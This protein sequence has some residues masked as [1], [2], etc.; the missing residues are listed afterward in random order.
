MPT[1]HIETHKCAKDGICIA[2]CPFLLLEEAE[3]GRARF[4][5][6]AETFCIECGHCL[7]VCP[8][9]A[10]R[11]NGVGQEQL[12]HVDRSLLPGPEQTAAWLRSRRSVRSYKD[13]PVPAGVVTDLLEL[14]RW[15]PTARNQ[16]NV[17]WLVVPTREKVRE[18]AAMVADWL[19][20]SELMP[21]VLARWDA[22]KD[23]LLRNAPVLVA[24]HAPESSYRP[25]VDCSIALTSL[26]LA[27]PGLGLG[28]CW[29]GFFM[30]AAVAYPP[31][32][33][34]LALPEGHKVF[35]ALM[36]GYP[37]YRYKFI[38]PRRELRVGWL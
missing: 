29:A 22:G 1:L 21:A 32:R 13:E 18:L 8:T 11:I 4:I 34:R 17:H 7:A 19:R 26:E 20:E 23:I 14:T 35:G 38:P 10:V 24:A 3:D 33:E 25:E 9:D 15:A 5:E 6:E 27:A 30:N 28:A 36:L 37:K 12:E 16:Q 2:E 31:L